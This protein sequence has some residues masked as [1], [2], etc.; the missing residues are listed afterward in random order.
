MTKKSTV[1]ISYTMSAVDN[2]LTSP[3]ARCN[4]S[5]GQRKTLSCWTV[6]IPGMKVGG[7]RRIT[8]PPDHAYGSKGIPPFISGDT[9][10]VFE[11]TVI[12]CN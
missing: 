9:A 11:V 6:G 12:K 2:Q 8:S 1:T 5:L 4:V 10:V 7:V 3:P